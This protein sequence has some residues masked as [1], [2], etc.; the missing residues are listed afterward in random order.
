MHPDDQAA[1]AEAKRTYGADYLPV[2]ELAEIPAE[3]VAEFCA[4]VAQAVRV[5][6]F[7]MW[8]DYD[9]RGLKATINEVK[10]A[11]RRLHRALAYLDSRGNVRSMLES[12]FALEQQGCKLPEAQLSLIFAG[13][14][15]GMVVGGEP[16]AEFQKQ[17]AVL[18]IAAQHMSVTQLPKRGKN[19]TNEFV[20]HILHLAKMFGGNLTYDKNNDTGT[21]ADVN[22][23][24]RARMSPESWKD[25]S[26][27]TLQNLKSG[28]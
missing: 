24:F 23:F 26:P 6:G 3:K 5:Y 4:Q 13:V 12:F 10:T 25:I 16:L 1:L 22:K 27:S 8:M 14:W 21:L 2:A 7:N 19:R 18:E 9:R 11:A 20:K 17:V 28:C 15:Q